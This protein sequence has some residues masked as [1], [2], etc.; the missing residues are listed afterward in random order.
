MKGAL[1]WDAAHPNAV[2]PKSRDPATLERTR[3]GLAQMRLK[4]LAEADEI[5]RERQANGLT[6]R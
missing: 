3:G 4:V 2:T 5:R 1:D 6:N